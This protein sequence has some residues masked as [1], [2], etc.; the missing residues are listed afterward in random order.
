VKRR[1]FLSLL[2]GAAAWPV[3]T[4]AQHQPTMRK[5]GLLHSVHLRL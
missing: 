1:D 4:R 5:V 2:G 3:W